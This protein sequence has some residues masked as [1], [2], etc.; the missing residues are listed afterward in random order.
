MLYCD[1][2][3][4]STPIWYGVLCLDRTLIKSRMYLGF[5]G[6][7]FFAD[8]QGLQDP[9]WSELGSRYKLLFF[10]ADG[11]PATE[12]PLDAEPNQ[13]T[14]VILQDQNCTISLYERVEL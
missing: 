10:P 11:S 1:L 12:I 4:D 13:I 2:A 5:I 3:V 8:S 14:N 9:E 6:E 7:L